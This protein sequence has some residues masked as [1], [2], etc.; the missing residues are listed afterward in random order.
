MYA[1]P[2]WREPL[3]DRML[4]K[5]AAV[6]HTVVARVPA[7][8]SRNPGSSLEKG[9]TNLLLR[10]LHHKWGYAHL[11]IIKRS[12]VILL[13]SVKLSVLLSV[14]SSGATLAS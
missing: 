10:H 1:V 7:T 8:S 2:T 9:K 13:I 4:M 6:S 5:A 14:M 11:Q 12:S 3:S